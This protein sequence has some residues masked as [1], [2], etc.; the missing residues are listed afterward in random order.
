MRYA[1]MMTAAFALI[2]VTGC[3]GNEDVHGKGH[4]A[5]ADWVGGGLMTSELAEE[6]GGSLDQTD[7][8]YYQQASQRALQSGANKSWHNQDTGHHGTIIPSEK[9]T[10]D[11]DTC[12]RY[13]QSI[14]VDGDRHESRA[15]ACRNEEG[16]WEIE[17]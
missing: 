10:E 16:M 14:Y 7:L 6:V 17:D 15:K 8:S 11:G 5:S 12:R 1:R 3:A 13:T 4:G 9:F 2:A